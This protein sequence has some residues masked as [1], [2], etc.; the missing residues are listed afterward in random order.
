M[1]MRIGLLV[2]Y[3][4]SA[5]GERYAVAQDVIRHVVPTNACIEFNQGAMNQVAVGRLKDAEST[6]SAAVG[7]RA[8]SSDQSCAWLTMHN[9]ALIMALSG[10]LAE[11]E[12]LEKRSL[13]ILE[14][15]Y[16]PDDPFLLRPL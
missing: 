7:D 1:G 3:V 12:M 8:G 4:C 16:P 10:R 2:V 15:G 13:K 11:A 6:L 14:T 5:L 9:L